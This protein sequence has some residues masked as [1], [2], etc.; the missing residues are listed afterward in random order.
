[1]FL[2]VLTPDK[3]VGLFSLQAMAVDKCVMPLHV[4]VFA[5]MQQGGRPGGARA[6]PL[7]D[8][9]VNPISTR[10]GAHYPHLVLRAPPGFSDL[11]TA[12]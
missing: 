9:S 12:L 6:P 2:K 8:R 4:I 5:G 11:A 7:F 1:M 10:G 3:M